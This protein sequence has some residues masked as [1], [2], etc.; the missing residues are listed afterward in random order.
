[1]I[2]IPVVIIIAVVLTIVP[3]KKF[4]DSSWSNGWC[5]L[6][7]V[8]WVLCGLVVVAGFVCYF[9]S[10]HR[11]S[12]FR[13]YKEVSEYYTAAVADTLDAS[14]SVDVSVGIPTLAAI[15]NADI[16]VGNLVSGRIATKRILEAR[17]YMISVTKDR[18]W[19]KI[20]RGRWFIRLWIASPPP[21][22]FQ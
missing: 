16:D 7:A 14:V 22:L 18:E 5:G 21:D 6:C 9:T 20:A 19:Y 2:L 10:I 13:S 17:S 15:L 12:Q 8:G 3:V 11:Y 1:M 4:K